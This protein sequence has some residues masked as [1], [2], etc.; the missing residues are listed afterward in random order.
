[1]AELLQRFSGNPFSTPVGQR[2]EQ[3]TDP[4]V[5]SENWAL[6]M[7]ICDII[8]DSEDGA[9]DAVRAIKKR[10]QQTAGKNFQVF[11]LTLIVLETCVK[12]CGKRFHILVTNK[13]FVQD[14]IKLIGPKNDPPAEIQEQVLSLIQSWAEAFHGQPDM[15][16]VSIVHNELRNKGIK[17]P[18]SSNENKVP[19]CTPQKS[20]PPYTVSSQID[21]FSRGSSLNQAP[22]SSTLQPTLSTSTSNPIPLT[23][24]QLNKLKNELELVQSNMNVFSEMLAEIKPGQEHTDDLNLLV[25]LHQT[26]QSMQKRIVELIQKIAN[27]EVTNELLK[28]NDDLNNLFMRYERFEKKRE[29]KNQPNFSMDPTSSNLPHQF[30]STSSFDNKISS[31]QR[32]SSALQQI[33]PSLIDFTDANDS[34]QDVIDST[35]KLNLDQSSKSNEISGDN[36]FDMFAQSRS[37]RISNRS[38]TDR[39]VDEEQEDEMREIERWIGNDSIDRQSPRSF[40]S[41]LKERAEAVEQQPPKKMNN[42]DSSLI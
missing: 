38:G 29:S 28:I 21:T 14:L 6:N 9:R 36:E 17:F 11:K 39:T 12:N 4:S 13:D 27:E 20:V 26:L 23:P 22:S 2:I 25:E 15:Q 41:F 8:N 40:Q 34:V 33:Q 10:L 37:N 16:G 35:D 5:T 3:A 7:E 18:N 42:Q 31:D 30:P 24:E 1:M 19:I 32:S